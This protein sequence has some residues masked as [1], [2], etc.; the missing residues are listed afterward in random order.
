LS[1]PVVLFDDALTQANAARDWLDVQEPGLG[2][3]F[4]G[5]LSQTLAWIGEFPQASPEVVPGVRK[6]L[7]P[8]FKYRIYY[9]IEPEQVVVI[10]IYP[11]A[12]DTPDSLRPR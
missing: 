3:R 1:L 4:G 6:A 2:D 7:L 5:L 8:V 12:Q 10:R 11:P 9:V